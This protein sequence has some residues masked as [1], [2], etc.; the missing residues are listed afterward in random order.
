MGL[1]NSG[2]IELVKL[3]RVLI[4]TL[5]GYLSSAFQEKQKTPGVAGSGVAV[6]RE[7]VSSVSGVAVTREP[8]SSISRSHPGQPSHRLA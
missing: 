7:L 1:K 4:R 3:N 5:S 2:V 6:M 8:V